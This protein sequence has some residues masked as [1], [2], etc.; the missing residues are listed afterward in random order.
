MPP[1]IRR[2]VL[3]CGLAL[4]A[5]QT[6]IDPFAVIH[7]R[8]LGAC[9]RAQ[10]GNGVLTAPPSHAIVLFRIIH[11][12][13]TKTGKTWPFDSTRVE[14]LGDMLQNLGGTGPVTIPAGQDVPLDLPVG[15]LV[16]TS[17]PDGTDASATNYQLLYPAAPPGPGTLGAKA[18]VNQTQYPFNPDCA[19]IAGL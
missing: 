14:I 7:Y 13:N 3:A 10:T 16:A 15:I 6:P 5:C 9:I 8:Q 12:D 18:N 17:N 4:A 11:I 1:L 2:A 19:A